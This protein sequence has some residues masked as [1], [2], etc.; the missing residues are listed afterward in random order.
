MLLSRTL[1]LLATL[2]L[3]APA[4][5]AV[6]A[7]AEVR[8]TPIVRAVQSASPAVVNIQGQKTVPG[9]SAGT[10]DASRQVNGM[11]TGVVIDPRGYIL[12]NHHVVD[13]VRQINVTLDDRRTYVARLVAHDKRTDLAVIKVRSPRSLP[14]IDVGASSDLMPGETVVAVG[15]AFGY[16]HTVTQG[17]ISALHRDVQV[18][19]TQSYDDLIQTDASINPGNSGGPLLSIEGRMIGVNVAVRAGAQGIGFAIPVDKAMDIAA[20][21]MSIERLEQKWHGL[22]TVKADDD[23]NRL[24]VTRVSSG[25]PAAQ[26]GLRP[27]D[28]IKR[29]GDRDA[30]RPLDVEL[31]LLGKPTGRAVD[32]EVVRDDEP[33]DLRLA[34]ATRGRTVASRSTTPSRTSRTSKAARPSDPR[35]WEVLGL[36]LRA[37]PRSTFT[38]TG[39]R[40]RGGMRVVSVRDGSP[41][42]DQGIKTGDILV[43]MHTWETASSQDIRYIVTRPNLDS[44]GSMKFYILRGKETLYGHM[45]VASKARRTT[46]RR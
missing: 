39:S 9:G 40:Y 33:L 42:D 46:S 5:R 23:D 6:A 45:N 26:S 25:S 27:G 11:G 15:N 16:E 43:G 14:T 13:G 28:V 32:V 30:V 24:I 19:E 41:A 35:A 12:T 21:L 8:L 37:E 1:V 10:N 31:A 34:L 22:E 4:S 3:G 29:I 7:V 18:S 2:A 36:N 38:R 17:I 44:I 20:S